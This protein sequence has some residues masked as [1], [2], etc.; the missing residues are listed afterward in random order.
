VV[1][2]ATAAEIHSGIARLMRKGKLDGQDEEAIRSRL[3]LM[4][5]SWREMLPSD[6]V[7]DLAER[8]VYRHPLRTAEAFQLAAALCWCRERPR[9]RAFVCFDARLAEAAE[10]Q[11]F[12]VMGAA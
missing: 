10:Q 9:G 4:R 1:W 8:L 6:G 7:R 12:E 5:R 3:T 11:G 2:W